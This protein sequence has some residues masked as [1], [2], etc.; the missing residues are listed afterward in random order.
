MEQAKEK[1]TENITPLWTK[2]FVLTTLSNFFL[3]F[4]FQLLIPTLPA[5]TEKIGGDAFAVGLVIGIFTVATLF[6]RPFVGR[7]LDTNSRSKVLLVGLI[8]F[9]FA[10]FSYN[11]AVTVLLILIIRFIQGIGWG[12]TTTSF[13]TIISDIIPQ[14][15][16]GEGMGYY[17]LSSTLAMAIGPV[18]GIKIMYDKGFTEIF[19]LGSLL[20]IVTILI[21]RFIKYPESQNIY[22]DK[23][24]IGLRDLYEK[25]ALLPSILILI[26]NIT[27]GGIVTFITLYGKE[28][29]IENVG[30]FFTAN[31]IMV[32]IT[33]PIAGV[34]F[35]RSGHKWLLLFGGFSAII[36]LIL[37]S[38]TTNI[39]M[40]ILSAIFYSMGFGTVQP[41]L[42]AWTINRVSP[43]RRGAANGT[44]FS[45]FDIGIGTGSILLGIVARSTTYSIMYRMSILFI[46]A[47]LFLYILFLVKQKGY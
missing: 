16:R 39:Y 1:E 40:L 47:Y 2:D 46:V 12:I 42:Q 31:A 33:R 6:T 26:F 43:E 11:F 10:I 17:G 44:Y 37:L 22:K 9:L 41:S 19:F 14:K 20:I 21:S 5:Y 34:I 25:D 30:W 24:K 7:A 4:S 3:F 32:L 38:Y 35:D 8:V 28:I 36:S 15:R 27:Y 23:P 29:N 45:A 18:V 13:G